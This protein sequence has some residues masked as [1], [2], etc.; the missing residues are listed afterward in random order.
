MKTDHT[1]NNRAITKT[2][3]AQSSCIIEKTKKPK[4]TQA[5]EIACDMLSVYSSLNKLY[6]T[7]NRLEYVIRK[8]SIEDITKGRL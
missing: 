7:L 1:L 4:L 2:T 8:K 5:E 3:Q 6:E